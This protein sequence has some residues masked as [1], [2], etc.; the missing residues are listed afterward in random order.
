MN[1]NKS[2]DINIMISKKSFLTRVS[3]R[4]P[5]HG[6]VPL[7]VLAGTSAGRSASLPGKAGSTVRRGRARPAHCCTPRAWGPGGTLRIWGKWTER[8]TP[9]PAGGRGAGMAVT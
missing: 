1:R 3:P 2:H 5:H 6:P 9:C 7:A 4:A 8:G